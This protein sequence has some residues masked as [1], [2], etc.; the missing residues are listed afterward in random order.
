MKPYKLLGVL[1]LIVA[2]AAP[3]TAW[4]DAREDFN[5]AFSAQKQKQYSKAVEYYT[6]AI[7]SGEL[8]GGNLAI[9]YNNRGNSY[10]KMGKLDKAMAD[11]RRSM[12]INPN[13]AFPVNG[14]GLALRRKG[15]FSQAIAHF[16]RALELNPKYQSPRYNR[17]YTYFRMKR[18]RQ[19][20]ADYD[21]LLKQNPRD[22]EAYNGRGEVLRY[23]KSTARP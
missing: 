6:R 13:Y 1:A 4:A 22:H 3:A 2:L 15:K 21:W 23:Q 18:Y 17:A 9:V 5:I 14:M 8:S 7:D 16:T 20:M 12:Q 19:A 10:A 11:Y